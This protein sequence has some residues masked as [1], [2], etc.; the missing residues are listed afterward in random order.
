MTA[1]G[2]SPTFDVVRRYPLLL[3]AGILLL[4][5]QLG[6]LLSKSYAV[7]SLASI[8]L[9]VGV[10]STLLALTLWLCCR[11]SQFSSDSTT[12]AFQAFFLASSLI[13]VGCFCGVASLHS[14]TDDLSKFATRKNEPIALRAVVESAAVWQPNPNHR[15]SDPTSRPWKTTW[16]IRCEQVLSEGDWKNIDSQT[17]LAV[18]GKVTAFLPGD[19]LEVYGA[20]RTIYPPTNPG[21]FDLAAHQARQ[22]RYVMISA[23]SLEQVTRLESRW[24]NPARR[25]RGWAIRE[26]DSL[27][28]E[29]IGDGR[30]P[31]AAALVFGQ[32]QQVDWQEQQELMATGTLHMLA[33][34][35][36]HVEIVAAGILFL[37]WVIGFNDRTRLVVLAIVCLTYAGL[38]AGKPPV[39][40]AT[41]LVIAFE[42]ARLRGRQARLTNLLSLAA[43]ILFLLNASN[44]ENVGGHLSF[45]AVAAIGIFV[46]DFGVEKA[47]EKE[48]PPL[49]KL[50]RGQAGALSRI[51][52]LASQ[53]MWGMIRLSFWV[54]LIT[55]PLVWFHFHVVAPIAIPLNVLVSIPLG[56]SLLT[57]LV[58]GLWG[59]VP[60]LGAVA[61]GACTK[62]LNAIV[63]LVGIGESI[64]GG[65]LWLPSPP[66][67]WVV[68]FYGLV[69]MWLV[70]FRERKRFLLGVSLLC[71]L[72]LGIT[73]I[74]ISPRG[75]MKE[76]AQLVSIERGNSLENLVANFLDVGHGTCVIVELPDGQVWVYDAGHLGASDRSHQEI[77]DALWSMNASR[78]DR[79]ILS[80]ADADHYNAVRGL[81][82][83]FQVGSVAT[84]ERFVACR[85]AEVTALLT[86]LEGR[87]I[88]VETWATGDSGTVADV[89]WQVLH[90][91]NDMRFESD[92]A[93]S[94][95]LL[96]EFANRRVLLPGDLDGTGM[97]SLLE[98]PDRPCHAL[99]APHHGSLTRDPI[100]LLEWC[101]P[102]LVVVSGNHRAA[103][104]A[105]VEKYSPQSDLL[106]ITFRDGAI[107]YQ[108]DSDSTTKTFHW[109]GDS[110]ESLGA[111]SEVV[112]TAQNKAEQVSN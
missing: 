8:S 4:G 58:T 71:L 30:A 49:K 3:S 74:G 38:A 41:I 112:R 76:A 108:V 96:F 86:D 59:W 23:D 10:A 106:G 22:G 83:R 94:L 19:L 46:L 40:R 101:R 51:F 25:L 98:L 32:R 44:I 6:L 7:E 26:I 85:D 18:E 2:W 33:I 93:S 111:D 91:H 79:L 92:N 1:S 14:G 24:G 60:G 45:L 20:Y 27:L 78:I 73:Q 34:S 66:V 55:C 65:H 89:E 11:T 16:H 102:E 21:A 63:W 105:V 37:C 110:W 61:G 52:D 103:R 54:W 47:Q 43:I 13:A 15:A 84:T 99:M 5:G 62:S 75:F 42:I 29:H 72:M 28:H 109:Q 17:T 50:L 95:C 70:L 107:R 88:S 87:G 90:P 56:F 100:P 82:E 97:F 77:A 9:L 53:W 81:L 57:G 48:L 67:W 39:M 35:G 64:Q 36:M 104:D 69:L 31:L 68:T 80:H 12:R